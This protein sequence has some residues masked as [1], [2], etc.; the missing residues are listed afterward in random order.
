MS[1]PRSQRIVRPIAAG[2]LAFA[3]VV[4]GAILTVEADGVPRSLPFAQ[5]WSDAGLITLS[6]DWSGVPGIEGFRGDGLA[7]T[8]ADPQTV[9]V[10]GS[11]DVVDVNANQA[12]TAFTTGGVAEFAIGD[13]VVG[14]QG[15]GTA[16]APY[17]RVTV[18]TTG[19]TGVRVRYNVRDVDGTT[20]NAVQRVALHYRVGDTGAW[21][22]VPAAYIA[23]ATTGPSQATLVTPVDVVLP[24]AADDQAVVQLRIMTADAAGSDEWVGIDDLRIE[25]A[26]PN[27]A[28]VILATAA[29]PN[30]V[31]WGQT[32]AVAA[33]V[34][35][36]NNPPSTS[37]TVAADTS[38]VAGAASSTPLLDNGLVPDVTAGDGIF[39]GQVVVAAAAGV[40]S[41]VVPI[42]VVDEL[43]RGDTD[44]VTVQVT[45]PILT[46]PIHAV[47]G[48]GVSSPYVGQ[49]VRTTGV[50]TG[51]RS[52]GYY[53]Q[54]PD[55]SVDGDPATS[56]GVF[57]FTAGT[58]PPA[59]VVGAA[60]TVTGTVEEFGFAADPAITELTGTTATV[61]STGNPLPAAIVLAAADTSPTGGPFQLE[62]LEGMRVQVS[63]L[64]VVGP[65]Q[66]SIAEATATVTNTGVFY[67]VITG[68]D[69]PRREPGIDA[70]DGMPLCAA[71]TGCAIP[72][73]DGNPERLRI[74]SDGL[75]GVPPAVVTTGA[76]VSGLVGIV[77]Y[78][79]RTWTLL[80]TAPVSVSN[81]ALGTAA[82]PRGAGEFTVASFNLQRLFDT[83][84][85][86]GIGD[87]AL[88]PAAYDARL[89]KLSLAIRAALGSPDVL[90][91]QEAEN[92]AVL[93]DLAARIDADA[94]AAGQPVPGY[95]AH[96]VEGNDPG[97]IDVGFLTAAR[98]AVT[99]V[100][101]HGAADTFVD[102]TDGSIDTLNDRPSLS[103]R[104]TIAAAPGAL[105]APVVVLVNHLRSLNDLTDPVAGP[106][107]RAKRL[108][109]AEYVARLLA[110]LRTT[111]PGVPVVSVGDYNAFDVNDGFVDVLGIARGVPAPA[112]EV[113]AFAGD[114]LTPDFV[115]APA[116]A[117]TPAAQA[118]SYVFDGNV[119]S[120]D[121]ILLS[122]EAVPA[123]TA[124]EHARVNADFPEVY[125]VDPTRVERSSDHDPAVAYFA[126]ARDTAAP[127]LTLPAGGPVPAQ[128]P[129]G[130]TV[131]WVA[132]AVDAV[133]GSRPVTC[134]PASGALFP[135]GT[136]TVT[137]VAS[138][139]SGNVATGGFAV[140]VVDPPTAG[141]IGG[142]VTMGSGQ[143]SAQLT[144]A[145]ARTSTGG[146][147]ATVVGL[148]RTG[149]GLPRLFVAT[150]VRSVGFF[151]DP[152]S[153]PGGVPA[154]GIDTTRVTGPASVNGQ[155]GFTFELV[156]TDRG[157]PGPGR[158]TVS[159]VVRTS[160]G[161]VLASW[162]G[163]IAGG[164]VEAL[165]SW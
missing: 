15:S 91:V 66:G 18:N 49:V 96:L 97:G 35:P 120:L 67:A 109:Q 155:G 34:A 53:L 74:D 82:R 14:L 125:R 136:T 128:G 24:A 159:F 71:G 123:L 162:T 113:V 10:D 50:V 60:V 46:L 83:V 88:T 116:V 132:T 101:Q 152:A 28:P 11:P 3:T 149:S 138:D 143:R 79:F 43:G 58:P 42:A 93:Q 151:D 85:D 78:G 165:P 4:A 114:L 30:P 75:V 141:L 22:N 103:L 41:R 150:G 5:D 99:A 154:S 39:T 16:D 112:T 121:H 89:A 52:N 72:I 156:A 105:P 119:Q 147:G 61:E 145:A 8:G 124:F 25:Q 144:L 164:N 115:L 130:A 54:T 6:D 111:Y 12:S 31:E 129:L 163:P 104:A 1:V 80:P 23:D 106:R 122:P 45:A 55:D 33:R 117:G 73:F 98:V 92:L 51:L 68:V 44:S 118:Y 160:T 139:L 36:G 86:P 108:A 90:G 107:V 161:Q 110:E 56:E 70:F 95:T 13:P 48:A 81:L 126:F 133:D 158:D 140:T 26:P 127:T 84:N 63:S 100:T 87:V 65:S 27:E 19:V 9:L 64:T 2:L 134:T 102:P 59:V 148:I 47:Q 40:G 29:A 20:D 77:D 76:T 37:L 38:A 57:V 32:L 146:A 21:T 137:C 7:S 135:Y 17:L 62:R 142:I 157:N 153:T 69:R 131:A 94:A